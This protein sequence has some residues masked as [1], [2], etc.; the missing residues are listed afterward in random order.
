M[1]GFTFRS[2]RIPQASWLDSTTLSLLSDSAITI[3]TTAKSDK[4]LQWCDKA[5]DARPKWAGNQ[6]RQTGHHT[7]Y[8]SI[9]PPTTIRK[10][11]W[12]GPVSKGTPW[13]RTELQLG[14]SDMENQHNPCKVGCKHILL[15]T[16]Q[17]EKKS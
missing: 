4:E 1:R 15:R 5:D 14:R 16:D 7:Q 10:P 6:Q 2:L 13:N 12:S 9:N 11:L 8:Q 3:D 17:V